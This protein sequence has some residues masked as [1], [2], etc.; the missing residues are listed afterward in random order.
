MEFEI[1]SKVIQWASER[2]IFTGSTPQAQAKK[3]LEEATELLDA[4]T[5]EQA[6]D[7]I[8]DILV[9]LIIG[10]EMRGVSLDDCLAH[11]WEQIKDR[12]GLMLH[13][14]FLKQSDIDSLSADGFS[15]K[16]GAL[17]QQARHPEQR[18]FAISLINS[19][20][21]RAQSRFC[22]EDRVW[23]VSSAGYAES[24]S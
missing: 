23:I 6:V 9:T 15:V 18:D 17:H 5:A 3:T 8:G 20:G 1:K 24:G 4:T 21:F 14:C 12:K 10:A 16:D 13:G 19:Y 7:A 2:G 11:A 22:G